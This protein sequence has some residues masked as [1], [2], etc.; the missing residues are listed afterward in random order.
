MME[1]V[2]LMVNMPKIVM[3]YLNVMTLVIAVKPVI[4]TVLMSWKTTWVVK[5]LKRMAAHPHQLQKICMW[6]VLSDKYCSY[7]N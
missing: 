5:R 6:I 3:S 4:Q 2:I 7:F 1:L